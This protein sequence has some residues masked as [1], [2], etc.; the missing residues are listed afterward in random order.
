MGDSSFYGI[1][2]GRYTMFM[3]TPYKIRGY[4][5]ELLL[6]NGKFERL[7]EP[8]EHWLFDPR[9]KILVEIVSQRDSWRWCG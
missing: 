2:D 7:L 5:Y 6:R 3:Q 8:G 4:E 9:G 1:N